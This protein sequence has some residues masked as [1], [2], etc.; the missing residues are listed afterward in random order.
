MLDRFVLP[1]QEEMDITASLLG[2]VPLFPSV[3]ATGHRLLKY[4]PNPSCLTHLA[5]A[6]FTF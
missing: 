1:W 4:S 3:F 2:T 6:G 5:G